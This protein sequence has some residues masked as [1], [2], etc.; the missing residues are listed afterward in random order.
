MTGTQQEFVVHQDPVWR[1]R[2]NFIVQAE[3]PEE[4]RPKRFEQLWARQLS[5]DRFEVCCIPFFIYNV[6]LGD[7]VATLPKAGRKYVV[8][9]AVQPS[10]R[11]VFRV[12]FGQSFQPRD[13]IAGEL[14]ALGSLVEWSSRNLLAVDAVDG[15]HAQPVA[16]F[17]AEREKAGHLLYERGHLVAHTMKEFESRLDAL[18]TEILVPLRVSKDVNSEAISELYALADELADVLKDEEMVPRRL[19]GKLWFVFTQM[20]AEADH[21]RMPDDILMS[22][23]GY[24]GR[25]RRMFGSPRSSSPHTPGVPRY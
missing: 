4:D 3:L 5:D 11:Y 12:W 9:E 2:S 23:W 19:T 20:L 24:Q 10:G 16:G 15:E 14:E 21:T 1:E 17:L 22:A 25:L 18:T 13:E 8:A 6:A 7:I